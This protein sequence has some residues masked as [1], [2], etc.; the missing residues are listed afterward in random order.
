[1]G[2]ARF[3]PSGVNP[4]GKGNYTGRIILPCKIA[5]A[6]CEEPRAGHSFFEKPILA[7]AGGGRV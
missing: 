3:S 1:M 4:D 5:G 2:N 6:A 7:K